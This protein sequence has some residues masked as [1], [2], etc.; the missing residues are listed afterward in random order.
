[1]VKVAIASGGTGGHIYPGIAIAEALAERDL[2]NGILFIGSEEGLEKKILPLERFSFKTIKARGMLRKLSYKAISAPFLAIHAMFQA[3]KLLKVFKPDILVTTGGYVSLP[4]GAAAKL[5]GIPILIHE[6]N[7]IPGVSNRIGGFMAKK[8]T[9]SFE[10]TQKYFSKAK[11][12]VTGN[13][14]RKR[15]IKAIKSV[16]IQKLGLDQKRK[17]LLI[18]GGSQ[19]ARKI[20]E[21]IIEA[22]DDLCAQDLQI[23]HVTGERDYDFVVSKTEKKILD[24][25]KEIPFVKGKKR[26]IT[27]AKFKQ[28]HPLS[29]MVNI[30]D[31]LAA[32][33]LVVSRAGGTA[34]AEITV[35]GL[36][37]VLIPFPF[38]ADGHQERN[39]RIL[40]EKGAALV[41][42]NKMLSK[43]SLVTI[44]KDVICHEA[45]LK[46]MMAASQKMARPH[47]AKQIVQ[48]IYDI[49]GIKDSIKKKKRARFRLK[50][51]T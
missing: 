34:I 28:Y 14:V 44:I 33:D 8:I 17:T 1:M 36:P 7:V 9:V 31:G 16:A 38:S 48:V 24:I 12:I 11:T 21:I 22:L 47:A 45:K 5:L 3:A 25:E 39:A 37:C 2:K 15:I 42:K 20:N 32:A 35:K 51:L 29:Y 40:K 43:Q 10:E 41:L 46:N 30:W 50:K 18:L 13:P 6:Q 27:L 23:I 19:G 26:Q 4:V 49:L